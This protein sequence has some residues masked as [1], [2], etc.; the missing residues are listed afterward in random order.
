MSKLH[1]TQPGIFTGFPEVASGV[2]L[3]KGGQ[4]PYLDTN[5][6]FRALAD[7]LPQQ[8]YK[9]VRAAAVELRQNAAE[10]LLNPTASVYLAH[11]THSNV[12]REANP[13][14]DAEGHDQADGIVTTSSNLLIGVLV[15][16]CAG[17]LIYDPEAK[18]IA[19]VHSGW[20]G[21]KA[22]IIAT[23]IA[24]MQAKG[25]DP[26]RLRVYISPVACPCHY[27]VGPTFREYFDERFLPVIDG[28]VCF[29]N[30]AALQAQLQSLGVQHIEL[31]MRCTVEE[32]TL[33]SYRRDGLQ[34]G[35][36]LVGI[37]LR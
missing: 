30:H 19:A 29:D 23:T 21:T 4:P 22:N 35:R 16:D 31:D 3:R 25:A 33:H 18:V 8:T 6:G 27:E 12:V 2:T 10:Q 13:H 37:G 9:Q 28:K 20:R 5:L 36:F 17:I 7:Q 11:Q 26:A 24:L 34:S 1:F 15:A 14:G 32:S